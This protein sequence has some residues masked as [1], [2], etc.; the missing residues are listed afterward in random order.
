MP[1]AIRKRGR[2]KAGD[3]K[4]ATVQVLDRALDVLELLARGNGLTLSQIAETTGQPPSTVHRILTTLNQRGMAESDAATQAWHVGPAC[5]GLGAAFTRRADIVDRARP[6]L[7]KLME[8]TGETANLGVLYGD[9]VLFVSQIETQ[10]PVRA[11]LA[12]G[13]RVP[14]YASGIGKALL[15]FGSDDALQ[16]ILDGPSLAG[17]TPQTLV[18]PDALRE[19]LSRTR[20]RGFAV[21]DEERAVGMRCVAAPV[22]DVAG[23]PIAGISI[24]GPTHRVGPAHLKTLG[25]VVVAAA[26][27]LTQAIGG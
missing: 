21:D 25:A 26:E 10:Q 20:H 27:E 15:A 2:P 17:F 14:L 24:S 11:C 4:P 16:A 19:D 23:Q 8:D 6:I 9:T 1:Q 7:H 5:F 3:Q 12:P 22:L 13:T 18:S